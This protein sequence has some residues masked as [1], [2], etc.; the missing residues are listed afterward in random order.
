[1]IYF[2]HSATTPIHP[3]VAKKV[4]NIN[5]IHYANPSSIY[6]EGRK[7]KSLIEKARTQVANAIGAKNTQIFFTSGG[8]EANNQ[9]LWNKLNEEKKHIIVSSIEHPAIIKVL[10]NIERYGITAS[11]IPVNKNGLV[12][13]ESVMKLIKKDTGLISIMLANN[14]VGTIQPIQEII[15]NTKSLNIPF[16][17]DA[18]QALGKIPIDVNSLGVDYLSLSAHKFYGPKGIGALFVKNKKKI[19]S[20]IIGGD[21]EDGLRGGTENISGIVGM[22][23]AA[24]IAIQNQQTCSSHLKN[25][26]KYFLDNLKSNSPNIIC[27]SINNLP[28]LISITFPGFQSDILM[29]KLDRKKIAVSNGSACNTGNIKP[30]N[31]LKAMGIKNDLNL[32]T[33]RFSFGKN[34]TKDE[35]DKLLNALKEII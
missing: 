22:G 27:N 3:L 21:Q 12:E 15:E 8:T 11:F 16:H 10:K 32:S 5:R 30:S 4:N 34:N 31:V 25:L 33:L 7:A 13:I 26:E 19:Q 14:E 2:D 23:L 28:G 29:A 6:S 18:V 1:M 20:L 24:E 35:V 17:T 9:V